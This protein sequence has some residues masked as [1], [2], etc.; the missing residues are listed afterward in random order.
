LCARHLEVRATRGHTSGC[1]SHVLDDHGMAFMGE[2]LP[3]RGGG[4]TAF[5][6][7]LRSIVKKWSSAVGPQQTF[8]DSA[9]QELARRDRRC[10]A[11]AHA[12]AVGLAGKALQV[13]ASERQGRLRCGAR[14]EVEAAKL[15]SF[16]ALSALRQSQQVSLRS[17]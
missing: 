4:R 10:P 2:S 7:T 11:G 6:A 14:P 3:I 15:A 1:L 17:A 8:T 9:C 16:A 13:A 12:V 5:H